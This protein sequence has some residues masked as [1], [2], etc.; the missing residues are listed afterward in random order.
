MIISLSRTPDFNFSLIAK[1]IDNNGLYTVDNNNIINE[2]IQILCHLNFI[3]ITTNIISVYMSYRLIIS[4]NKLNNIPL[5]TNLNL[6][7][8]GIAISSLLIKFCLFN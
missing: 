1:Y 5:G 8:F 3:D 4:W 2:G 6:P 7:I